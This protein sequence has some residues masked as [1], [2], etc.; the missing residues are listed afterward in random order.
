MLAFE[1]DTH[2]TRI[3]G[4]GRSV[5]EVEL[6]QSVSVLLEQAHVV[7]GSLPVGSDAASVQP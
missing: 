2:L 5:G 3:L 1:A 4:D 6:A 7:L